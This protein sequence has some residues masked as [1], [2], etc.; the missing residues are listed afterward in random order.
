MHCKPW[1]CEE[2]FHGRST[3]VDVR[4]CLRRRLLS[5]LV[6]GTYWRPN[7]MCPAPGFE[8]FRH[9]G[10]TYPDDPPDDCPGWMTLKRRPS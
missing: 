5:L 8:K 4:P 10:T 3:P 7:P 2:P 9:S 6:S 1:I